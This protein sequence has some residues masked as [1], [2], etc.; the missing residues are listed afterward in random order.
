MARRLKTRARWGATWTP[1]DS[2]SSTQASCAP[3][4]RLAWW[5]WLDSRDTSRGTSLAVCETLRDVAQL[6]RGRAA[7]GLL[8]AVARSSEAEHVLRRIPTH[9]TLAGQLTRHIP[10]ACKMRASR[11]QNTRNTRAAFLQHTHNSRTTHARL[12]TMTRAAVHRCRSTRSH[13][14]EAR[15]DESVC[16]PPTISQFHAPLDRYLPKRLKE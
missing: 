4:M 5:S 7:E 16:T 12:N 14:D 9:T 11:V 8:D 6:R 10:R 13:V 3:M 15:G 1:M 2:K